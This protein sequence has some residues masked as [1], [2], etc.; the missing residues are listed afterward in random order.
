MWVHCLCI[1]ALLY[2]I[3]DIYYTIYIILYIYIL[4]YIYIILYIFI[5]IHTYI[6]T[7][8]HTLIY[9]IQLLSRKK[10]LL[11]SVARIPLMAARSAVRKYAPYSHYA[12]IPMPTFM[13]NEVKRKYWLGNIKE[14]VVIVLLLLLLSLLYYYYC[15]CIFSN[16][17]YNFLSN[18][19]AS[20]YQ[21]PFFLFFL[22]NQDSFQTIFII[23]VLLYPSYLS[24]YTYICSSSSR[25]VLLLALLLLLLQVVL[26]LL[27]LQVV[28]LLL[29]E[30]VGGARVAL[31]IL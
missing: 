29:H 13:Y 30:E 31:W 8:I 24:I 17:T 21:Q 23:T 9:I 11:H 7:Y 2:F 27:L 25:Q 12:C 16:C 22:L 26:L 5:L 14:F 3:L 6:H 20:L 10:A 15:C 19:K 4:Y 1:S 18:F 28:L